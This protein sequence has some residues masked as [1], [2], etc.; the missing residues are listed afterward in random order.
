M[1]LTAVTPSTGSVPSGRF[2]WHESLATMAI[3]ARW[4]ADLGAFEIQL[5]TL[6]AWAPV[7][8][9]NGS[10]V[11]NPFRV[12]VNAGAYQAVSFLDA[13][14]GGRFR[15]VELQGPGGQ[16]SGVWDLFSDSETTSA[17]GSLDPDCRYDL[18]DGENPFR[19]F[20]FAQP[21]SESAG[22]L[23]HA[24]PPKS[25]LFERV[26]AALRNREPWSN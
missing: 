9:S 25:S 11:S 24:T 6:V 26:L 3:W 23:C 22:M 2:E 4:R 21:P 18:A 1:G 20:E 16:K 10:A 7:Y 17:H 5:K 13:V 14:I 12:T 19:A 8:R 15:Y